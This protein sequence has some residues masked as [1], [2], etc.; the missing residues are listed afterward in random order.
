MVAVVSDL[1]MQAAGCLDP[2]PFAA[3]RRFRQAAEIIRRC[4][5]VLVTSRFAADESRRLIGVPSSRIVTIQG[6]AA[7]VLPNMQDDDPG[8][9]IVGIA[10]DGTVDG[11]RMLAKAFAYARKREACRSLRLVLLHALDQAGREE[12]ER[13]F[14]DQGLDVELAGLFDE[15]KVIQH[16]SGAKACFAQSLPSGLAG[17]V[18]QAYAAG[19]AVFGSDAQPVAELV[20]RDC[21]FKPQEVASIAE[22]MEHAQ[23]RQD[24]LEVSRCFGAELLART[25]LESAA[26]QVGNLFRSLVSA[27]PRRETTPTRCAVF[28]PLSP[29]SSGV[30]IFNSRAFSH[31]TLPLDFFSD[32][33]DEMDLA[34][35]TAAIETAEPKT[36]RR[37]YRAK[38]FG[39]YQPADAYSSTVF[40]IGNS[41]HCLPAL[42]AAIRFRPRQAKRLFY[43]HDAKVTDLLLSYFDGD[44]TRLRSALAP[45][46]PEVEDGAFA[47][48]PNELLHSNILG[49]RLLAALVGSGTI[50]VNSR[51]AQ[52]LIAR[53]L[54]PTFDHEIITVF[55]PVFDPTGDEVRRVAPPDT[56]TIGHFGILGPSK[57]PEIL[58]EAA[59]LLARERPV[60]LVF[61]GFDVTSYLAGRE[62]PDFVLCRDNVDEHELIALMRGVDVAVQLRYPDHGESS[63][64]I[65]QLISVGKRP[66]ITQGTSESDLADLIMAVPPFIAPGDLAD[67]IIATQARDVGYHP[68]ERL[69]RSSFAKAFL[70]LAT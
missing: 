39:V 32:I 34:R 12:I 58:I 3:E 44:L 26:L 38:D 50:L 69:S 49:A 21:R 10:G 18:L 5:A 47:A 6:G 24:L 57:Q 11:A 41:F 2:E 46:Y 70:P 52:E 35:K 31:L 28:G 66:I 61:A 1:P 17:P 15:G 19:A 37:V 64:V 36:E 13:E 59:R 27:A 43:F 56:L 55:H 30:A 62:V 63:G 16:L 7:P 60:R 45:Y 25:N 20:P 65:R 22:A 23:D 40:V 51:R 53:D 48:H 4:D 67:T 54:R 14:R 8:S 68:A 29:E 33:A 9:R 42:Q